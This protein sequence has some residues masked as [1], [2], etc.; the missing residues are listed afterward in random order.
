MTPHIRPAQVS[1][2]PAMLNIYAAARAFM[3]ANGNP[4]QWGDEGY[5]QRE[6]LEQDIA[7]GRSYVVEGDDGMVH[8]VFMFTLGPDPTYAVIEDGQWPDDKPYGV[9]HRIAGDGTVKGLVSLATAFAETQCPTLRIDTHQDNT[10]MQRALAKNGYTYCGIIY[11][12]DGTPRLAYH[13]LPQR[14]AT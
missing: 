2:L 4:H 3:A 10:V 14:N 5:P 6:L 8:G 13:R 1:D 7:L 11:T 12:D 9:I